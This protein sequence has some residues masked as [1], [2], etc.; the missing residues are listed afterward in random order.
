MNLDLKTGKTLEYGK[1]L[2]MLSSFA[3]CERA[4][5]LAAGLLPESD[6]SKAKASL[7]ETDAA[8]VLIAKHSSPSFFQIENPKAALTKAEKGATLGINEILGI[9]KILK[10]AGALKKYGEKAEEDSA[11]A[12]FFEEIRPNRALFERIEFCIV[13]EN[14][15]N[16]HASPALADLRRKMRQASGKAKE[17]LEKMIRSK[18]VGKFLQDA[19]I[20]MRG[21]RYVLPVKSENK[22][23][24]PGIV[25]DMSGSGATVFVEPMAVIEANNEMRALLSAEAQEI[26]RILSELSAMCADFADGILACYF[27]VSELD[28]I[29]AKAKFASDL[30]AVKPQIGDDR[31]I[32]LKA[33]RH[34]LIDRKTVQPI[35]VR[36]GDE[37]ST[38]VITGPNTGGKTVALKTIGL[39]C[40][41]AAA[42]LHIPA[43]EGS[44][45]SVFSHVLAD[46]GD[47]QS[48]EQSLSTFSA[49]M[50]NIV[51]I[52]ETADSES[53]V[54]LDELGAGTD[55]VEGAA[56]AIAIL[57][58]LAK[59]GAKT[60]ATTH[61]AELKA[62]AL[63]TPRVE[64]ASCEFNVETLRPT[65]KLLIGIPGRS[66]AF[67]ISK[68][69]GLSENIIN[70]A[71][72]L[73]SEESIK[74]EE[75]LTDIEKKRSEIENETDRVNREKEEAQ[76]IKDKLQKLHEAASAE[77]DRE[78]LKAREDA[79]RILSQAKGIYQNV[80][81]ELE[82]LKSAKDS[83]DFGERLSEARR[84]LKK[85]I[86]KS[87][88]KIYEAENKKKKEKYTLP[89][90][91]KIGDTVR[92]SD[93]G[94]EA[95]VLSL[96]DAKGNLTVKAGIMK[97][98]TNIENLRL[99][100]SAGSEK[101][102]GGYSFAPKLSGAEV[103]RELDLRGKMADEA[104]TELYKF[105][106]NAILMGLT[107]VS[108]IHGKGT[109]ALRAAVNAELKKCGVKSFR[110]GK[111]GEGDAG[112]TVVEL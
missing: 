38:L 103:R 78:V 19:I 51:G 56:L 7:L 26:E 97:I 74:F 92:I 4:K 75:V 35:N 73:L 20:T 91:L 98:E 23:E 47:E 90:A 31:I 32:D 104:I 111:Y 48:I 40:L 28:F 94:K 95:S 81:K 65:Y 41:M 109:G 89:R 15:I 8:K 107:E 83:A 12:G 36:L 69:L 100:E 57:E 30:R 72:G 54:L 60:A 99:A 29:F 2:E 42:G 11:I 66:N 33:A 5:E 16:D 86:E 79:K 80:I 106:D 63:K 13:G 101:S 39:L 6:L 10:A 37:F 27:S 44:R 87:E 68:R 110:P 88:D 58:T 105:L 52:L 53:L 82:Q 102:G 34:P 1:I 9:A 18:T 24:V 93:L 64:N 108:I 76:A 62:Y 85:D 55:P 22:G 59:Y 61:Y 70:R 14:E 45:V 112:V 43:G 21:D 46:I 50:R 25:H 84:R 3:V 96:P 67:A 17:I 77:K 71:S 49:H